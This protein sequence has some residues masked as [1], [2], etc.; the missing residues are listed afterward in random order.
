M[1]NKDIKQPELLYKEALD[2]I[3]SEEP[4]EVTFC[5]HKHKIGWLHNGTNR[6]FSHV[7][8]KEKNLNK[9]NVK[10]C[11]IIL[12][13]NV[14]KIFFFYWAYWRYLYYIKD[15]DEV[16][17]LKV[18]DVAKKK[19]QQNPFSLVTILSIGMM[20]TMMTMTKMEAKACQA[21]RSGE[22]RIAS[23]KNMDSSLNESSE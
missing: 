6:K 8:I 23:E 17:I 16:E 21:E 5:G 15:L 13:N 11:T 18:M 3:M 1:D 9:R 2:N 19:I 7:M 20:D 10:V 22:Q 4:T 12:L 14:F